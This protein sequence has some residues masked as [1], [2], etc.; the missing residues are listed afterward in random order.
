MLKRHQRVIALFVSIAFLSLLPVYSHPQNFIEK[1]RQVGYQ[2]SPQNILPVLLGVAV[3]A[4]G[5]FLLVIL[6]S[7]DKYDITGQWDFHN[8]YTTDGYADFD[9]VWTFTAYDSINKV[10][11][12]YVRNENGSTTQGQYTVVNKFEVVFQDSEVT[13]QYVGQ[14]DSKTTMSGTF[15]IANGAKGYWS[16]KKKSPLLSPRQESFASGSG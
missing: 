9:S 1:E 2:A 8:D 13:E 3:V 15:V 14:F 16:A 7:K 4:A 5:I 10:F 6:V 12:S 11:G